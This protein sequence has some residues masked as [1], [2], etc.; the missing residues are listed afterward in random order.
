MTAPAVP[1][2]TMV[3]WQTKRSERRVASPPPPPPPPKTGP[4]AT[5]LVR[6]RGRPQQVPCARAHAHSR[7][8]RRVFVLSLRRRRRCAPVAR[9]HEGARGG[10][11]GGS[12]GRRSGGENRTTSR[13]RLRAPSHRWP[14]CVFKRISLFIGAYRTAKVPGKTC[15]RQNNTQ[16]RTLVGIKLTDDKKKLFSTLS[17]FVLF[18]GSPADN[19]TRFY[20]EYY[21][22]PRI[23]FS[24][25]RAL[26]IYR[27]REVLESFPNIEHDSV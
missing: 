1:V 21:F 10:G 13:V 18:L 16:S 20:A 3:H 9:R 14:V 27:T 26:K 8:G 4:R 24:R 5:P 25:S 22:A 7:G 12:T 19:V 2:R 11:S 23:F 15:V 6:C 17:G